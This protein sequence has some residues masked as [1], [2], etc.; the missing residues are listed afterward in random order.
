MN[1]VKESQITTT[2]TGV[3]FSKEGQCDQTFRQSSMQTLGLDVKSLRLSLTRR[4]EGVGDGLKLSKR[5]KGKALIPSDRLAV[6][7]IPPTQTEDD[8]EIELSLLAYDEG[9]LSEIKS[10]LRASDE[11]FRKATVLASRD[12]GEPRVNTTWWISIYLPQAAFDE[13]YSSFESDNLES[14]GFRVTFFNSLVEEH[15]V[16]SP[17]WNSIL[18]VTHY[19]LRDGEA[20]SWLFGEVVNVFLDEKSRTLPSHTYTTPSETANEDP[21][22]LVQ[23]KSSAEYQLKAIENSIK[24][25]TEPLKYLLYI[26]CFALVV[27][28]LK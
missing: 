26:A 20:T 28:V 22:R 2:E 11:E 25:L 7:G 13:I 21:N 17:E 27:A 9:L 10:N 19:V 16:T 23:S 5:L 1:E 14:L 18:G 8:E 6:V 12:N 24:A 4:G 3:I 15:V